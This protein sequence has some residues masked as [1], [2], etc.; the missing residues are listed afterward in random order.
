MALPAELISPENE[1]SASTCTPSTTTHFQHPRRQSQEQVS[2]FRHWQT[3]RGTRWWDKHS[4]RE[5]STAHAIVLFPGDQP[6]NLASTGLCPKPAWETS[7]W[8]DL[9]N[10]FTKPVSRNR[11]HGHRK[12]HQT[13]NKHNLSR[14]QQVT[15]ANSLPRL[16]P[17]SLFLKQEIASPYTGLFNL[18]TFKTS[19]PGVKDRRWFYGIMLIS[20]MGTWWPKDYFS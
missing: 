7:Y 14:I 12:K 3:H 20:A 6:K 11:H 1:A 10:P 4:T 17:K 2:S 5:H 9:Q 19:P 18:L 15:S 13:L 16:D 8:K